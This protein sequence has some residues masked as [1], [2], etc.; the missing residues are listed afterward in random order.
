MQA[1]EITNATSSELA[2]TECLSEELHTH[3]FKLSKFFGVELLLHYGSPDSKASYQGELTQE[4]SCYPR[5]NLENTT[6]QH[7]KEENFIKSQAPIIT[8]SI[9]LKKLLASSKQGLD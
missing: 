5:N 1:L 9:P 4:S 7:E 2:I 3:C 6:H 8:F